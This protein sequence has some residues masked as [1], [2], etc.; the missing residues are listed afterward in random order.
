MAETRYLLFFSTSQLD[1]TLFT[2]SNVQLSTR[3]DLP[4]MLS[5]SLALAFSQ[6]LS[7]PGGVPQ[8]IQERYIERF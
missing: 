3:I 5:L 8:E 6:T 7:L 4:H 1:S 2:I